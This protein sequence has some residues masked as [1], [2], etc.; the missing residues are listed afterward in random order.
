MRYTI[1]EH[2]EEE[3]ALMLD[4]ITDEY[5][6]T[7]N[8]QEPV[9]KEYGSKAAVAGY[10]VLNLLF[11]NGFLTASGIQDEGKNEKSR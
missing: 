8:S 9:P 2:T 6:N 10:R 3:K 7:Y 1:T 11:S 4:L 5:I